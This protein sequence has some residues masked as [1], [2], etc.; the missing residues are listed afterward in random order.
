MRAAL[1]NQT[2]PAHEVIRVEDVERPEPGPGEVRVKIEASGVNPTDWKA[3]AGIT[4]RPIDGFQI[5][6]HDGAGVIDAVGAGVDPR[7]TGQRVWTWLAAAGRPWGTAAEWSVVPDRQAVPLPAGVSA[8]L[9][10]SLG[11]PAM[12]AHRCLFADGPVEGQTI[13]VA[14]GAGAVG[15]FAIELARHAGARV[16]ATVSGPRKAELAAQAGASLVVNYREPGAAD[17]I[18]AFAGDRGVDRVIELALGA[19]LALDLDVIGPHAQI[20]TYAAEPQDPVLPVRACMTANVTLRFVLLYGVPGEAL[21]QAARD[22]TTALTDG[23]LTA[24]PV[25]AF[26]LEETTAAHEAVAGGAVGKVL[27]IPG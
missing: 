2:G 12:T 21:E 1:Y 25:T 22:I 13:L 4:P 14:G 19:N 10:A 11:V 24:L 9:G 3:R 8:E 16:A 20:V 15:H 18:L 5:P 26:P 6:H 23:A 27:V 17:Q 7:R